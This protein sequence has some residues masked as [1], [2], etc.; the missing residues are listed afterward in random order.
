MKIEIEK[1]KKEKRIQRFL[2]ETVIY[3]TTIDRLERQY[4]I[5][6]LGIQG[7]TND[8]TLQ[9][10]LTIMAIASSPK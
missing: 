2:S 1:V 4:S 7:K 10:A 8:T 3:C 6:F 5:L 9:L